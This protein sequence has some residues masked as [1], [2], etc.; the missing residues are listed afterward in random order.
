MSFTVWVT[1]PDG[2]AVQSVAGEIGRRLEARQVRVEVLD[3]RT[4]GIEALDPCPER[5]V[6]FVAATL[7]RHG[8]ATVVALAADTRAGRERARAAIP[9]MIEVYVRPAAASETGAYEAPERPEVEATF[10]EQQGGTAAEQTVRTLEVLDFLAR[11][12]DP[13]YSEEEERQVIRRLKAFGYL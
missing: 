8:I 11:A 10:P 6:P 12:G 1:G 2:H 3:A 5:Q 7:A 9:R 13:S 4:R